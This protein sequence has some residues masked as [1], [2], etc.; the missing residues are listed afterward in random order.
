MDP[1]PSPG[2][3]KPLFQ[4]SP[5]QRGE[6]GH[7]ERKQRPKLLHKRPPYN[8]QF[9]S[10]KVGRNEGP[11]RIPGSQSCFNC[12]SPGHW[13]QDCPGPRK[14]V[15]NAVDGNPRP[16]KRQK[17]G[18]PVVT[19]YP[20]SDHR[21]Q[22]YGAPYMY[23]P[24][25]QA[26]TSYMPY[27]SYPPTPVSAHSQ[28]SSPWQQCPPYP[29]PAQ[30]YPQC[31][32]YGLPTPMASAN[33]QFPSPVSAH[34][35]H[36]YQGYFPPQ[37]PQLS[38]GSDQKSSCQGYN[39]YSSTHPMSGQ[40]QDYQPSWDDTPYTT[41]H[42]G[43]WTEGMQ[44]SDGWLTSTSSE[45]Q[46]IW[47]P[48]NPVARPLSSRFLDFDEPLPFATLEPGRSVSKYILDKFP[49][50]FERHIRDT[51]DWPSVMDDPIFREIQM[52]CPLISIKEL[53]SRREEVY[54]TH[55][56]NVIN[57][58]EEGEI[59]EKA[60]KHDSGPVV[61]DFDITDDGRIQVRKENEDR[62]ALESSRKYAEDSP[63]INRGPKRAFDEIEPLDPDCG[64]DRDLCQERNSLPSH[65]G[66]ERGN[67]LDR[68]SRQLKQRNVSD[69]RH[70]KRGDDFPSQS[71]HDR[72]T[73]SNDP[74]Q[75]KK[76]PRDTHLTTSHNNPQE[77]P[78][79]R[80]QRSELHPG[81]G[82]PKFQPS[83]QSRS[84]ANNRTQPNDSRESG[85]DGPR[86]Q[87][88]DVPSKSKRKRPQI[89]SAYS[90]RW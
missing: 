45:G 38:F 82:G 84:R 56:V 32:P 79:Q 36:Q 74:S 46:I 16:S 27:G 52:D 14:T 49:A 17:I 55:N 67:N 33:S 6:L 76:R 4:Q 34:S 53:I 88:D 11:R 77:K 41:P 2:E 22:Q 59:S 89:A 9:H 83:T 40:P 21:K 68:F 86:R 69:H 63:G 23:T 72:G 39:H 81:D 25:S 42:S 80:A 57:E 43:P 5:Q 61:D 13:A 24:Q 47:R 78:Q 31:G 70:P 62:R 44:S 18:E 90:R 66:T 58:A 20:I 71:Y 7:K 28:A 8:P 51:E 3:G 10:G 1:Y 15:P 19:R 48:P 65:K 85:N 64:Y 50:E 35:G 87:E 12:G 29:S 54:A 73:D 37:P 60:S 26:Q 75:G 30:P